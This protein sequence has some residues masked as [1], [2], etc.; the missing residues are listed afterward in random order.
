MAIRQLVALL[1]WI[2]STALA[3]AQAPPPIPSLPDTERR[4]QYSVS[5]S[6]GPLNVG[7]QIYGDDADP[8]NWIQVYLNGI[9]LAQ[10][11]NWTLTSPSGS[12]GNIA[13]P[14]TDA[15][16]TFTAAQTGTVQ[17]VGARRPRRATQFAENRG[18]TARDLNQAISDA[19]AQLR[20]QWDLRA[21]TLQAP[22]GETLSLLPPAA[23]RAGLGACFD[24]LGNV[25][26]CASVS[27]SS[28][29]AGTG[30]SFSGTNPTTITNNIQAGQGI[31]FS[32][33]N[34]IT[35]A[36]PTLGSSGYTS[37]GT[38][39]V[40]QSITA[41]LSH[42]L[43]AQDFGAVCDGVTNDAAAFQNMLNAAGTLKL[44]AKF[45]GNC[46]IS[47]TLSIANF[48][49]LGLRG[50]SRGTAT[51]IP[52]TGIDAISVTLS[53][54]IDLSNFS[55]QYPVGSLCSQ[56]GS[57]AAIRVTTGSD[58]VIMDH[59]LISCP[60]NG[61]ILDTGG[62]ASGGHGITNSIINLGAPPSQLGILVQGAPN[63]SDDNYISNVL[64]QNSATGASPGAAAILCKQCPGLRISGLKTNGAWN[65]G[66]QLTISNVQDG[67]FFVNGSSIEGIFGNGINIQRADNVSFFGV[68]EIVG[69]E[70]SGA[71]C[72]NAGTDL[73]GPWIAN[74]VVN[75]NI[76]ISNVLSNAIAFFIDSSLGV[77]LVGNSTYSIGGTISNTRIGSQ[78]NFG[79]VGPNTCM[80]PTK[81][82]N[83]Y[84]SAVAC[85]ANSN[86]GSNV[87]LFTPY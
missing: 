84:T 65:A 31:T 61:I 10:S 36:A 48:Q 6:T 54:Y 15:Q 32:G 28:F 56:V 34:P 16:I 21:R 76:C 30:I 44:E 3:I 67:D 73:V 50:S 85:S 17:I 86:T 64:I 42:E 43:W 53:A 69:N 72:V 80:V 5:N 75:S 23:N 20:E 4:T 35:I 38:G 59:L 22:P 60:A 39:A 45:T 18:V 62:F 66:I 40:S 68:I 24:T 1:I 29:A 2:F 13:R 71:A 57:T 8:A 37:P 11:G 83:Q 47:S 77:S 49:G 79:V 74:L 7:F 82:A 41:R 87:T 55:I 9:L 78:V 33:T 25:T 70:L 51:L 27:G 81:N 19:E 58:F 63:G 52:I 14:I 12:L 46:A 26:T